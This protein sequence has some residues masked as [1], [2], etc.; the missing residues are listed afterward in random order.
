M[1]TRVTLAV[2]IWGIVLSAACGGADCRSP[3][4]AVRIASLLSLIASPERYDLKY[5]SVSGVAS[6]TQR[7]TELYLHHEDFENVITP[8]AVLLEGDEV[9][10]RE[11]HGK[12][13]RVRG[14]FEADLR[15]EMAMFGGTITDVDHFE[16]WPLP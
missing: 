13:V 7:G 6:V 2:A 1:I 12:R 11:L 8:N 4:A 9:E 15:G 16:E 5:V 14:C 3:H 10:A